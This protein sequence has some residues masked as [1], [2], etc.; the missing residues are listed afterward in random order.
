MGAAWSSRPEAENQLVL[1]YAWTA[2]ALDILVPIARFYRLEPSKEAY[3]DFD[4]AT[5]QNVKAAGATDDDVKEAIFGFSGTP[6]LLGTDEA[7]WPDAVA[8]V[9]AHNEE[10]HLT[11]AFPVLMSSTGQIV[12]M[13]VANTKDQL[14]LL[15]R[16]PLPGVSDTR[17]LLK[18]ETI[19]RF[20]LATMAQT[21]DWG[22]YLWSL[23]AGVPKDPYTWQ[24]TLKGSYKQWRNTMH[25]F[26][27]TIQSLGCRLASSTEFLA[28][29]PGGSANPSTDAK[30]TE[31]AKRVQDEYKDISYKRLFWS[32][33]VRFLVSAGVSTLVEL[34]KRYAGIG[35]PLDE[36]RL[37]EA[38]PQPLTEP[39]FAG[40]VKVKKTIDSL[41]NL[42][43][44]YYRGMDVAT[45]L[46]RVIIYYLWDHAEVSLP[47]TL[48]VIL[49][50]ALLVLS[51]Q[52]LN[53]PEVKKMFFDFLDRAQVYF[54][55][56]AR[57]LVNEL[58]MF[59]VVALSM[60]LAERAGLAAGGLPTRHVLDRLLRSEGD[61]LGLGEAAR[62]IVDQLGG[63]EAALR[64]LPADSSDLLALVR[65][66]LG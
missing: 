57:I 46:G 41:S 16:K 52:L 31:F 8:S 55:Y 10:H 51:V 58:G 62:A 38:G 35:N 64:S 39:S 7:R 63:E 54:G 53:F 30:F 34:G 18:M 20:N 59:L 33:V 24:G 13:P 29:I 28:N 3:L 60:V 5:S 22:F 15:R 43:F 9:E 12:K 1:E 17:N 65:P 6:T 36:L 50:G 19:A 42:Q 40:L 2:I 32:A 48:T 26:L 49:T 23:T 21:Q 11:T 61:A 45:F 25:V 47:R 37:F 44:L 14:F 27:Y 56:A 4:Y 66:R